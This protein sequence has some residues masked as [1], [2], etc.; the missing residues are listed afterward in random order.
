M[1]VGI[2]EAG[3]PEFTRENNNPAVWVRKRDREGSMWGRRMPEMDLSSRRKRGRSEGVYFREVDV[4]KEDT[5]L[6]DVREEGTEGN[7]CWRQLICCGDS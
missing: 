5:L 3:V 6:M 7:A 2:I 1:E 4:G